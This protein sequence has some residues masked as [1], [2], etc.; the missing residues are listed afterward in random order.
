MEG[1]T[2]GSPGQEGMEGESRE[3]RDSDVRFLTTM[4]GCRIRCLCRRSTCEVCLGWSK[5]SAGVLLVPH[6]HCRSRTREVRDHRDDLL[7]K[8]TTRSPL[9]LTH[10]T[11][12]WQLVSRREGV[13]HHHGSLMLS[14]DLCEKTRQ[15]TLERGTLL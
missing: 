10:S 11:F 3:G 15:I 14:R 6:E 7:G 2:I 13:R 8:Y 9:T 12:F 4:P 5:M 1:T